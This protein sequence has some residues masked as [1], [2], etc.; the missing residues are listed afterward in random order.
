MHIDADVVKQA[1][2]QAKDGLDGIFDYVDISLSYFILR[3]RR[4]NATWLVKTRNLTR[5]FGAPPERLVRQ[6]RNI[7]QTKFARLRTEPAPETDDKVA[8]L[9]W[10]WEQLRSGYQ[11]HVESPRVK[12]GRARHASQATGDDVALS[13]GREAF[14]SWRTRRIATLT[15][16]DLVTA[17]KEVQR[18]H[19]HRQCEKALTYAKAA[20][21]WLLSNQITE[22]G[23]DQKSP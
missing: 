20:F 2:A 5:K 15:P 12:H 1:F 4:H 19:S 13:L 10:T 21:T 9:G 16:S 23:L 18:A 8:D 6:A 7:A 22:C 3:V 11:E 17:V 14:E